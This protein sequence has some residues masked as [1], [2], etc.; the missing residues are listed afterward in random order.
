[1]DTLDSYLQNKPAYHCTNCGFQSRAMQWQ[2]P[3]CK[4]WDRVRP[5]HGID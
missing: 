3:S 4:Q 2:C 5:I 1:M